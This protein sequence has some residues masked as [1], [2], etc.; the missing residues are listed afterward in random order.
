MEEKYNKF[1]STPKPMIKILLQE[2]D[3]DFFAIEDIWNSIVHIEKKEKYKKE[4]N[5]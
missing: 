1:N 2:E 4:K 5:K 3:E